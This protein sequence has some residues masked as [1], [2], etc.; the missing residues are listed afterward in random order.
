VYSNAQANLAILLQYL[1]I[2][3]ESTSM[4]DA[5]RSSVYHGTDHSKSNFILNS[6]VYDMSSGPIYYFHQPSLN[7]ALYQ[8]GV[9][10]TGITVFNSPPQTI[11]QKG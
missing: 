1:H 6:Y 3:P 7:Y 2:K 10:L 8:K 11:K 9:Q 5:C 4:R